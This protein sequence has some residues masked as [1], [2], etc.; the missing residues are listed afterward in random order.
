MDRWDVAQSRPVVMPKA[1]TTKQQDEDRDLGFGS[2]VA[3][4]HAL[5]LLNRDG[6]FNV[7]SEGRG[8]WSAA[9]MYNALLTATW[10]RFFGILIGSYLAVNS[11]FALVYVSLGQGALHSVDHMPGFLTAFFFSVHTF[12][13]IGYGTIGPAG[14]AANAIVT[15]ESVVGLLSFALITGLV[16]A[17]F[18]RPTAHLIYSRSAI[19]APYRGV[20]G[21]EFR[22]LNGRRSQLIELH[23]MVVLSRF[24]DFDRVRK[25]QFYTLALERDHVAFFPLT[26]TIVH[27]IDESSPLYGWTEERLKA[28]EAEFLIL[29]TAFDETFSQ[30]VHS[31]TS[32]AANEVVWNARFAGAYR[33]VP[34][35]R[36]AV[37]L[38][39]MHE[40]EPVS[41]G[42][43]QP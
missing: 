31:R 19:V 40:I 24:E 43:A 10:P 29:I 9:G 21:F 16:F 7:A 3:Q 23:A 1:P 42:M 30:T 33:V 25:R 11:L 18:S 37:D 6:S 36:F 20:R 41:E 2:L 27:P 4:Q 22:V 13:T 39:R 14:I 8:F 5:R 15:V 32:Y 28:A 38:Q 12:A 35:G 26:W 34:G 17:R